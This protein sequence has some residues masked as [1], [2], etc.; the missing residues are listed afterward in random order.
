MFKTSV[1]GSDKTDHVLPVRL[2]SSPGRVARRMEF[3]SDKANS[4]GNSNLPAADSPVGEIHWDH[5]K[6]QCSRCL[7]LPTIVCQEARKPQP[8]HR[9]EVKTI[10]PST[11]GF[12]Y[13]PLLPQR[14]MKELSRQFGPLEGVDFRKGAQS[15]PISA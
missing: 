7:R 12:A 3:E 5:L 2:G 4:A 14:D 8:F 9:G 10:K 11:V 1:G 6:A 13:A 15:A